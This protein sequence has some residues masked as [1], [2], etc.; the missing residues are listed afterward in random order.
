M[1]TGR[2]LWIIWCLIWTANWF[3]FGLFTIVGIVVF[4]PLAALS[5]LAILIPVG[6]TP[7]TPARGFCPACGAQG[8][9]MMLPLHMQTAHGYGQPPAFPAQPVQP[10]P[11]VIEQFRGAQPPVWPSY[12]PQQQPMAPQYPMLPPGAR[13]FPPPGP[14]PRS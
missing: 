4:W 8:D 1:S 10:Q 13:P 12:G 9:P 6:K 7:P 3:F 5:V 11:V 2:V 14:Q